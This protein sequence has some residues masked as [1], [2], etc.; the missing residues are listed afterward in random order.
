M[1]DPAERSLEQRFFLSAI[2]LLYTYAGQYELDAAVVAG[3]FIV[4]AVP[5]NFSADV[6]RRVV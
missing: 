3:L 6:D 4:A 2:A 5:T 1:E